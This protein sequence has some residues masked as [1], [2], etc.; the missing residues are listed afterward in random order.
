MFSSALLREVLARE[1]A[2]VHGFVWIDLLIGAGGDGQCD[3]WQGSRRHGS[4][5]ERLVVEQTFCPSHSPNRKFYGRWS[6]LVMVGGSLL[7]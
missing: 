5:P 1:S 2:S 6:R 7:V 4:V 3:R